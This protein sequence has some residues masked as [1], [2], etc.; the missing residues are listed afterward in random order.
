TLCS[1]RFCL[2]AR[3]TFVLWRGFGR[4]VAR[5]TMSTSRANA[6]ARLRS[7]VRWLSER[8][9]ITRSSVRRRPASPASRAFTS[10]GNAEYPSIW[11][12]NS[13]AVDTLLTFCPPGP[14]ARTKRSSRSRSSSASVG[15]TGIIGAELSKN[16]ALGPESKDKPVPSRY[17]RLLTRRDVMRAILASVVGVLALAACAGGA[18]PP[19]GLAATS[20]ASDASASA[21]AAAMNDSRRPDADKARDDL[22]HPADILAFAH[23]RPG[24]RIADIGPGG[25]YYT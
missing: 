22:R 24:Q 18:I 6:S 21:I 4:C 1:R 25:G 8:I 20:H 11:N 9:T 19:L 15:V 16:R 3:G 10:G 7:C 13:T 5:S 17:M 14:A 2:S 12:R 23:V